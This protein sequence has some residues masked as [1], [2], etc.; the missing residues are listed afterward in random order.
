[1]KP[2]NAWLALAMIAVAVY[3]MLTQT[4]PWYV[5]PG[6]VIGAYVLGI[7]WLKQYNPRVARGI[8]T[9]VL[10]FIMGFIR[11]LLSSGRRRW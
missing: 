4:P 1:M 2:L 6:I 5:V 11:G 7:N 9:F 3:W 10:I 8:N